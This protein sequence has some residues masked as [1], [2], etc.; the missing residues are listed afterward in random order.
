MRFPIPMRGNEPVPAGSTDLL[1]MFPIPMR[2]NEHYGAVS[3]I[4][5]DPDCKFPIP[6]RG[7]EV[8]TAEKKAFTDVVFPIPMRGNEVLL[9]Q[10]ELGA[11]LD[12]FPIPM[13][14]NE[15]WP[16]RLPAVGTMARSF[17]S[18]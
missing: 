13:R 4:G 12:R 14:G 1:A 17:R 2:G 6:M 18:P 15:S 5:Y 8:R 10:P 11:L 3:K 9:G 16:L 7:N